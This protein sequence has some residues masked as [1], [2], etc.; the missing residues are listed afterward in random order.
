[1]SYV[2]SLFF[3]G[4][5]IPNIDRVFGHFFRNFSF[6]FFLSDDPISA[7]APET[8]SS[9]NHK[10]DIDKLY[11]QLTT[12]LN[13]FV[14]T[15]SIFWSYRAFESSCC[16]S[17]LALCFHSKKNYSQNVSMGILVMNKPIRPHNHVVSH[18]SGFHNGSITATNM[19]L[20]IVY[21]TKVWA[22]CSTIPANWS[23]SPMECRF[24]VLHHAFVL[25][26][27]HFIPII[28][29]IRVTP[30]VKAKNNTWRTNLIHL[31]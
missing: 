5:C 13:D 10:A 17:V 14:C 3:S 6:L 30:T 15:L 28:P 7:L 1:M 22:F 20:A 31:K 9:Q 26:L 25:L 16:F 8:K 4:F 19:D 29:V 21:A 27:I 2:F 24:T 18:G 11:M 12:V 23:S